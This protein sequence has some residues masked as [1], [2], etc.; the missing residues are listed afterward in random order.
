MSEIF[1]HRITPLAARSEKERRLLAEFA[2][3]A[4]EEERVLRK[5][6]RGMAARK[7]VRIKPVH[8]A[9]KLAKK[10]HPWATRSQP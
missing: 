1:G 8:R 7:G 9:R 3:T 10:L 5:G 4:E 2:E 6:E